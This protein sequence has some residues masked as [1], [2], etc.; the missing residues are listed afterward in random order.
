MSRK[1]R[2][3]L[4]SDDIDADGLQHDRQSS[5]RIRAFWFP[6]GPNSLNATVLVVAAQ[7]AA[8]L[9]FGR[10]HG[11]DVA[12]NLQQLLNE[13][14]VISSCYSGIGTYEVAVF[15]Y[16]SEIMRAFG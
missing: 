11:I 4:D 9:Q 2:Q 6:E 12:A 10:D 7:V 1:R 15:W 5:A 16:V 14:L 3:G 8:F 13:E